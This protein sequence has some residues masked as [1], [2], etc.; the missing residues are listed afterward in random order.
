[1]A[2][3]M[4]IPVQ[5]TQ[6]RKTYT[7]KLFGKNDDLC[8]ALQLALVGQQ[9]F[10]SSSKYARH[11]QADWGVGAGLSEPMQPVG[12]GITRFVRP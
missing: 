8:I 10:Y 11:R 7:G 6:V 12:A 3:F 1:M 9:T 4:R 2:Y 5:P